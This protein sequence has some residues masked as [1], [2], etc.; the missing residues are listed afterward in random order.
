[1]HSQTGA[2]GGQEVLLPSGCKLCA[3]LTVLSSWELMV[4]TTLGG[5]LTSQPPIYHL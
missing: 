5:E 4:M 3:T 2:A 1:M